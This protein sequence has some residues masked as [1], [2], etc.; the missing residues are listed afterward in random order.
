MPEEFKSIKNFLVKSEKAEQ[1][2]VYQK[3]IIEYKMR[4]LTC[5][6][7]NYY[8]E[9]FKDRYSLFKEVYIDTDTLSKSF[10]NEIAG[11]LCRITISNMENS[12]SCCPA[13]EWRN[14][15]DTGEL[16]DILGD[17]YIKYNDISQVMK[18]YFMKAWDIDE[19]AAKMKMGK[20]QGLPIETFI[21]LGE[22]NNQNKKEIL[23][24]LINK[25]DIGVATANF[26]YDTD[27][28]IVGCFV[29]P[30]EQSYK[31]ILEENTEVMRALL[32]ISNMLT[33][34][35]AKKV[36]MPFEKYRMTILEKL[37]D[38]FATHITIN[39]KE[40]IRALIKETSGYLNAW[41]QPAL[42]HSTFKQKDLLKEFITKNL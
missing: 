42:Y 41:D 24:I 40:E 31:N 22:L 6:L 39:N 23:A 4:I 14:L 37:L 26:V 10:G 21:H 29:T 5:M 2:A 8:W 20:K 13:I 34:G 33:K 7:S 19:K 12:V 1:D 3:S 38:M 16:V 17:F 11:E 27:N 9:N 18:Q 35:G 32:I 28:K 15:F 25:W 36:E 30:G